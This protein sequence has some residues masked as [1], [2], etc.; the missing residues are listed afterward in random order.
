MIAGRDTPLEI[1][2]M[3]LKA[4]RKLTVFFRHAA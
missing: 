2:L 3:Y 4:T 1:H